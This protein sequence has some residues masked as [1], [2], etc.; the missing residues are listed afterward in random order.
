MIRTRILTALAALVAVIAMSFGTAGASLPFTVSNP[1]PKIGE[2]VT[3][4]ADPC[5][6]P[7]GIKWTVTSF[8]QNTG[9]TTTYMTNQRDRTITWTFSNGTIY[10][11]L[12]RE[13]AGN[14]TNSVLAQGQTLIRATP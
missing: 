12:L 4:V 3:F 10:T 8:N 11:I 7:C 5:G 1:A 14:G 13:T 2:T 9:R 6:Q